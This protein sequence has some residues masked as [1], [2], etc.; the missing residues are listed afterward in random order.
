VSG[1]ATVKAFPANASH[2]QGRWVFY[3]QCQMP[4]AAAEALAL[5]EQSSE[6]LE[7]ILTAAALHLSWYM[8][9]LR[10]GYRA[11]DPET[12]YA[13]KLALLLGK[14]AVVLGPEHQYAWQLLYNSAYAC[15]AY[16]FDSHLPDDFSRIR[17]ESAENLLSL[18]ECGPP[19]SFQTMQASRDVVVRHILYETGDIARGLTV[20]DMFRRRLCLLPSKPYSGA[21]PRRLV[22]GE[23]WTG[24]M[25][26]IALLDCYIKGRLLGLMD[27]EELV[28]LA[29]PGMR[30]ANRAFLERWSPWVRI[31][32]SYEDMVALPADAIREPVGLSV[33]LDGREV[34]WGA[35]FAET[36]RLWEEQG[37]APLMALGPEDHAKAVPLLEQLGLPAKRPHICVHAR[38][39]GYHKE[40]NTASQQHRNADIMAF[41]PAIK[42]LTE[43]GYTV[44]RMGDP[45]MRPF[46]ALPGV[47]DYC[48]HPARDPW[49]DVYLVAS[50][51]F[52]MGCTS[53]LVMVAHVFGVP[54]GVSQFVPGCARP[55]TKDD[56]FIPK[57]YLSATAGEALSFKDA[58][59]PPI[60]TIFY[61]ERLKE[62]GIQVIDNTEDEITDLAEEILELTNHQNTD[63]NEVV[64]LREIYD[65]LN[66]NVPWFGMNGRISG[67]FLLRHAD[68]LR[69]VR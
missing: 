63:T 2:A 10:A 58:L 45:S 27:W 1:E 52:F 62:M 21:V 14:R 56:I 50:A 12:I 5:A 23:E 29:L 20:S 61:Y 46:P 57:R 59:S 17:D 32:E 34:Y 44:I 66:M 22:F 8:G 48:H 36:Q 54:T 42:R 31:I 24:Y 64:E 49:L 41:I 33:H 13:A 69:E 38:E 9:R 51:S 68:L 4:A 39:A 30:V 65:R 60:G 3:A 15:Q 37:R 11:E 40:G 7:V 47:I 53:G 6:N 25:G 43:A 19:A 28:V 18:S 26:H 35:A 16:G 67:R 55:Y